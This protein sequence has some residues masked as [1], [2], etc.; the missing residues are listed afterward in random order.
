M[1]RNPG[2]ETKGLDPRPITAFSMTLRDTVLH[3]T[4]TLGVAFNTVDR[5]IVQ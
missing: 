4:E 3:S 5:I 1:L 2:A